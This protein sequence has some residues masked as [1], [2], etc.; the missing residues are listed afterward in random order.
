VTPQGTMRVE[1][2]TPE[3]TRALKIARQIQGI[4]KRH[5]FWP[6]DTRAD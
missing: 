5:D 4:R 2:T 1:I 3:V 6:V